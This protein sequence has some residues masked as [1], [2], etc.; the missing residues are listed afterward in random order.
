MN[1]EKTVPIGE[2]RSMLL[3]VSYASH[4]IGGENNFCN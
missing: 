4:F 3:N 2:M 1:T